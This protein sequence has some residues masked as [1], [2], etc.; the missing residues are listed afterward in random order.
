MTRAK[1]YTADEVREILRAECE[2]AGSQ[3]EWGAR[4]CLSQVTVSH[5]MIGHRNIGRRIADA[6]GLEKVVLYREKTVDA[7]A[8]LD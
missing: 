6:L 7:N 8:K 4:H 3:T 1:T 5:T 2:K